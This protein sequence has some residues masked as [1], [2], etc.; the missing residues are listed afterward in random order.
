MRI[1]R[2]WIVLPLFF[3][4]GGSAVLDRPARTA[5]PTTRLAGPATKPEVTFEAR[6]EDQSLVRV[7]MLSEQIQVSTPYGRLTVPVQDIRRIE[8]GHH[9]GVGVPKRI[10]AAIEQLAAKTFDAR[11]AAGKQLLA[12]GPLSYPALQQATKAADLE[13]VRRAKGLL[14]KLEARYSTEQLQ[15]RWHD[16][17]HTPTF[18]IAGRVEGEGLKVKTAY[19]G[20]TQLRLADLWLLRSL[21]SDTEGNVTV[22]SARYA[23]PGA[24]TWMETDVEI[25]EGSEVEITATGQIDMWPMPGGAGAWTATPTGPNWAGGRGGGGMVAGQ[26]PGVLLGRIGKAGKEITLGALWN[27]RATQS[28]RLYLRISPSPWGN[29]ST[30]EYKVK[31]RIK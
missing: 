11:E 1:T 21:G 25:R 8:F 17:V 18:V 16:L 30:G 20:E 27:E 5:A 24:V 12:L 14:E 23:N 7:R 15:R 13:V 9:P 19:F 28:G 4:L 3:F 6:L 26:D 22:D 2:S 29:A 10:A 31:I